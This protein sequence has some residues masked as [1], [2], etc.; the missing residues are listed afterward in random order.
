MSAQTRY[1]NDLVDVE[2]A[3]AFDLEFHNQVNDWAGRLGEATES[4]DSVSVE[5]IVKEGEDVLSHHV[6]AFAKP[7]LDV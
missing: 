7:S 4:T 2:E 1:L 3:R 5:L 6:A